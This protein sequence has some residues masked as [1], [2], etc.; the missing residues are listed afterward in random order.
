MTG[1]LLMNFPKCHQ[2]VPMSEKQK[3]KR[4]SF[5]DEFKRD[6]VNLV[7]T[8]GYSFA[9]ASKAVNVDVTTLRDWHR[10]L[11]PSPQPCGEN[12]TVEELTQENKRLRKELARVE[13]ERE[14]LV[15]DS[16]DVSR[17]VR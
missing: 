15:L 1:G 9:A 10:K 3:P 2:E 13:M 14:R 17:H 4:R 12:A 8:Q 5:S 7:V 11:A 16:R 6:A